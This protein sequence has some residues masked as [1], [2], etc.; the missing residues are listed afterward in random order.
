MT[1]PMP[2]RAPDDH[3]TWTGA[4]EFERTDWGAV[5]YQLVSHMITLT[6]NVDYQYHELFISMLTSHIDYI[7]MLTTWPRRGGGRLRSAF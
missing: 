5:E 2:L 6:H 4:V 3:D 7:S 1:T